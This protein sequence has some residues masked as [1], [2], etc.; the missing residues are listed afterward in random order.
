MRRFNRVQRKCG[1][2]TDADMRDSYVPYGRD[3]QNQLG[4]NRDIR[5]NRDYAWLITDA[6][7]PFQ[8]FNPEFKLLLIFCDNFYS[9]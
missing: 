5:G 6:E 7:F 9:Y 8:I 1:V 4:K 3:D 2:E